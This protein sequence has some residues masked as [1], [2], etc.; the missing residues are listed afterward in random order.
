V[1]RGEPGLPKADKL[2]NF[3]GPTTNPFLFIADPEASGQHVAG[4]QQTKCWLLF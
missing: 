3:S 1:A 4:W 2:K